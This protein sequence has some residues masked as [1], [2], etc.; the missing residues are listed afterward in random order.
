M[1]EVPG[2]EPIVV[3]ELSTLERLSCNGDFKKEV[4]SCLLKQVLGTSFYS[5]TSEAC[6]LK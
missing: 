2:E 4:S 3:L 6:D 5:D 1:D